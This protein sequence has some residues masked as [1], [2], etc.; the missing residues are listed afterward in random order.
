MVLMYISCLDSAWHGT[1]IEASCHSFMVEL[2]HRQGKKPK[3]TDK[4]DKFFNMD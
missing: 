3:N 4:E 1:S 2:L